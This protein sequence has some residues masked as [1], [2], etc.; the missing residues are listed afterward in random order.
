[1]QIF[2]LLSPDDVKM[3]YDICDAFIDRLD[4]GDDD[5]KPDDYYVLSN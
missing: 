2:A 3:V 1:M 4:N 5:I